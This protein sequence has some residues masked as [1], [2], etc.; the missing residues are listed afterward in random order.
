[1]RNIGRRI[2][3][4]RQVGEQKMSQAILADKAGVKRALI[5]KIETGITTGSIS[6][7]QKIADALGVPLAELL[8][9]DQADTTEPDDAA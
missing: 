2:K 8:N 7:L 5:A 3:L 9:D 6:T 1:M 4:I